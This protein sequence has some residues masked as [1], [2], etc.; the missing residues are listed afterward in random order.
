M[1]CSRGR[2]AGHR[3]VHDAVA[4]VLGFGTLDSAM[5]TFAYLAH[6]SDL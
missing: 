4:E 6:D 3:Q 1:G 5:P 2:K